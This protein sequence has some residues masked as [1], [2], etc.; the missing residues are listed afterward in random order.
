MLTKTSWVTS[1][2]WARS[3]ST[4][5]TTPNTNG[6]T[7]SYNSA[8]APW[9]PWAERSRRTARSS[10]ALVQGCQIG[11][12]GENHG[13]GNLMT[14]VTTMVRHGRP[15]GWDH[16]IA[17]D[18]RTRR[19]VARPRIALSTD[20]R[21]DPAEPSARRPVGATEREPPSVD[22]HQELMP[23]GGTVGDRIGALVG[24]QRAVLVGGP[25]SERVVARRGVPGVRPL[26]PGVHRVLVGQRRLGPLPVVDLYLDLGDADR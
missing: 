1:S 17:G 14:A 9:S 4:R 12:D 13:R 2:A 15:S 16:G 19:R 25:H 8:N 18:A 11:R 22:K 21:L 24:L 3:R 10:T 6:A 7:A 26:P 23:A 5:L 20:T